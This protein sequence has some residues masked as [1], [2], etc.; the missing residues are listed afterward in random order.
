MCFCVIDHVPV[1]DPVYIRRWGEAG[2]D[3]SKNFLDR[4]RRKLVRG[5]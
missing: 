3:N 5:N 4:G 2:F 1:M